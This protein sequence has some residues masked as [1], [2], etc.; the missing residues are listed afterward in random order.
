MASY[1]EL[2]FGEEEEQRLWNLQNEGDSSRSKTVSNKRQQCNKKC[3]LFSE[4]Y[5]TKKIICAGELKA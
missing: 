1:A 5:F 3:I 2:I 4:K